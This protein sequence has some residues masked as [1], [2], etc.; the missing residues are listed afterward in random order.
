MSLRAQQYRA[1]KQARTFLL[2][3]CDRTYHP[4]ISELRKRA[5]RCLRHYPPP[6]EH[7]QPIFSRDPFGPDEVPDNVR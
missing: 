2:D 3:L 5:S 6:D 1:L 4:P 7:G